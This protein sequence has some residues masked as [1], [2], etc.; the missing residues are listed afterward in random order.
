MEQHHRAHT[1][2]SLPPP[3][4]SSELSSPVSE[5]SAAPTDGDA[6]SSPDPST[7]T[8]GPQLLF[9]L[10]P[11]STQLPPCQTAPPPPPEDSFMGPHT[12]TPPPGPLNKEESLLFIG[13]A[14]SVQLQPVDSDSQLK[15]RAAFAADVITVFNTP[16][17]LLDG[18]SISSWLA[19][20]T[21]SKLGT[22]AHVSPPPASLLAC[23]R[24]CGLPP[25]PPAPPI[26]LAPAPPI[27][28][29]SPLKHPA[30]PVTPPPSKKMKMA[31]SPPHAPPHAP[32]KPSAQAPKPKPTSPAPVSY[33][34]ITKS[35][36]RPSLVISLSSHAIPDGDAPLA[37]QCTPQELIAHLNATLTAS[38]HSVLLS[39]AQWT[40]KHNL[41]VTGGPDTMAHLLTAA[42]SFITSMLSSYLSHDDSSPLPL[43]SHEN[44]KWS[45]ILINGIPTGVSHTCGAYS[46][47]ECHDALTAD[48]PVYR[49]L[50]PM[51]P[52][53]WVRHPSGYMPGSLS[54]LVVAFKDPDGSTLR[55]LLSNKSPFAYGH[56]GKVKRWKQKPHVGTAA[57]AP[58]SIPF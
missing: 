36:A 34:S 23:C 2:S 3:A 8:T 44:V 52:P 16:T 33:S 9:L 20:N 50:R 30:V 38:P 42:S 7:T 11:P 37:V 51:Q 57:N 22:T 21:L 6:D 47:S 31:S 24:C 56:M 55:A 43:L 40:V 1:A 19:I 15:H 18:H 41:V 58:P 12:P 53:S 13:E 49:T 45:C 26:L 4:P 25:P 5:L 27:P 39:A 17:P 29:P 10:P 48:N 46:P 32:P 54:S 14:F 35:L 28:V